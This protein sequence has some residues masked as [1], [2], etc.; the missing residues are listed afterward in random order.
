MLHL[1]EPAHKQGLCA[2]LYFLH[3]AVPVIDLVQPNT[4]YL[5][6]LALMVNATGVNSLDSVPQMIF[7]DSG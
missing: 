6:H 5:P 2:V 3:K 4:L 1:G 7:F